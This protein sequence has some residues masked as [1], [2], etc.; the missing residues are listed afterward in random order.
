MLRKHGIKKQ[1]KNLAALCKRLLHSPPKDS[2]SRCPADQKG[3]ETGLEKPIKELNLEDGFDCLARRGQ[4]GANFASINARSIRRHVR[5]E[6]SNLSLNQR[7]SLH[8]KC[9]A[10]IIFN[11]KSD[12]RYFAVEDPK[13]KANA[14]SDEEAAAN[15][16]KAPRDAIDSAQEEGSSGGAAG[17]A[18]ERCKSYFLSMAG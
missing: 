4:I 6:R 9:K 13:P 8:E 2:G 7:R 12:A 3:L 10:Q 1:P 14:S 16:I 15:L 11:N 17:S 18:D 5:K